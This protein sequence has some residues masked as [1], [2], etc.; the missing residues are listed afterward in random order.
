[1]GLNLILEY[2]NFGT[3]KSFKEELSIEKVFFCLAEFKTQIVHLHILSMN[4]FNKQIHLNK[5]TKTSQSFWFKQF[6]S[7]ICSLVSRLAFYCS[8]FLKMFNLL[9]SVANQPK[10]LKWQD[11]KLK[12][13]IH[14]WCPTFLKGGSFEALI[15]IGYC[16][17]NW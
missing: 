14:F 17:Y 3:F 5:F 10:G 16:D 1:M 13:A 7:K 8:L 2:L 15:V 4:F 12:G 9:V 6:I 11:M